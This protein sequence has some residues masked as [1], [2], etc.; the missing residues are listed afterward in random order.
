M[1]VNAAD[2]IFSK[3]IR[4]RDN[5]KCQRCGRYYFPPTQGL[6]CAHLISRGNYAYRFNEFNAV[7]MCYGC[8]RYFDTKMSH[9]DRIDLVQKR[10]DGLG[11]EISI[12]SMYYDSKKLNLK[13]FNRTKR[14]HE[15]WAKKYYAE[16]IKLLE[17]DHG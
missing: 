5:W 3:Y 8:H 2:I 14:E 1:K 15:Q 7:A 12:E 4:S 9:D 6:H 16:K 10:F 11:L 13:N 17:L